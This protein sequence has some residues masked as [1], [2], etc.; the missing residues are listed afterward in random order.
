MIATAALAYPLARR[1][2]HTLL[3]TGGL[4]IV[5]QDLRFGAATPKVPLSRDRLRVLFL[6]LEGEL[7]DPDSIVSTIGYS[8]M[9]PKWRLG[10]ML[11]M[12][13]GIDGLGASDACGDRKSTRLNSS[14]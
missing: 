13:Q 5:N 3:A 4:D 2:V 1:Q 14:H 11:E 8:G 7:L 6:R 9:E 10:G 12:R